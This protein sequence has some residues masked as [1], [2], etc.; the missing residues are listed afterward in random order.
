MTKLSNMT[1]RTTPDSVDVLTTGEAAAQCGVSFRTVL[2][3]IERG[4]LPAYKLP[5]RGDRRI[6]RIDL[7]CFMQEYGMAAQELAPP[8]ARRVLIVDDETAMAHAIER[9]LRRVGCE[10][11]IAT[12]GF[13]AGSV[14][15]N[16]KPEVMTLDLRMP[17]MDGLAVLRF[18]AQT[19]PA[20]RPKVLII[21]ADSEQRLQSALELGAQ[22]VLR[23]PFQNEALQAAV[24]ALLG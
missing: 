21:S 12:N 11:A 16:W 2:R 13:E 7:R 10:T 3:W 1:D 17:G 23:K 18:L 15:A 8:S 4:L 14:L 6:R 20:T 22:A 19:D 9:V 5:G 24:A